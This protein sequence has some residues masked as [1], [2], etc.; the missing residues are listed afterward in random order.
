MLEEQ[1]QAT[2]TL[3]DNDGPIQVYCRSQNTSSGGP[4]VIELPSS[5]DDDDDDIGKPHHAQQMTVS[6]A[7]QHQGQGQKRLCLR[8]PPSNEQQAVRQQTTACTQIS[9]QP[10]L[11]QVRQTTANQPIIKEPTL[12]QLPIVEPAIS[13]PTF[14]Q[15]SVCQTD[16][17]V[18]DPVY[19][20]VSQSQQF[21]P[22]LNVQLD[23][24]PLNCGDNDVRTSDTVATGFL[25]DLNTGV[26][27]AVS[28]ATQGYPNIQPS[29][30]NY[31]N[32]PSP[33][34]S[35]NTSSP[36]YSRKLYPNGQCDDSAQNI[37]YDT[38]QG[39]LSDGGYESATS[40]YS[41][42]NTASP[43]QNVELL[44]DTESSHSIIQGDNTF[45]GMGYS[46]SP[47]VSVGNP[48]VSRANVPFSRD[49]LNTDN[50]GMDMLDELLKSFNQD[51]GSMDF[52]F[53]TVGNIA[54]SNT[55]P[56]M[57]TAEPM[58][59]FS[60]SPERPDSRSN[61]RPFLRSLLNMPENDIPKT[62][63]MV[64]EFS[65]HNSV[66]SPSAELSSN[67]FSP[68]SD[69]YDSDSQQSGYTPLNPNRN[70]T[71]GKNIA[72]KNIASENRDSMEGYQKMEISD[73][74]HDI[75]DIALNF[76]ENLADGQTLSD[77]GSDILMDT[78]DDSDFSKFVS[79]ILTQADTTQP[80][81]ATSNM[82]NKSGITKTHSK[83]FPK[84]VMSQSAQGKQT[85][86]RFSVPVAPR[87]KLGAQS[88]PKQPQYNSSNN[89]S[90]TSLHVDHGYHQTKGTKNQ[91]S[92]MR[93]PNGT[94]PSSR[95]NG[96]MNGNSL[97]VLYQGPKT[98][99]G[100]S[101]N[102]MSQLEKQLRG[103]GR[104]ATTPDHGSS[105]RSGQPKPFLEQLLT[106]ELTKD[107]YI[108]MEKERREI[109]RAHV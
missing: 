93:S 98:C 25:Q 81:Y 34:C 40:P 54:S 105:V 69:M 84:V 16:Q 39:N 96:Q 26:I 12:S 32:T 5:D 17:V 23:I 6:H 102:T 9:D 10:S 56:T 35:S 44:Q 52:P 31:S 63:I 76:L 33:S 50:L 64:K 70:L 89:A 100:Q 108:E 15:T 77:L 58:S 19:S 59:V 66:D 49:P 20:V 22:D 101:N 87:T 67:G 2:L 1:R 97:R 79:S 38:S 99:R 51:N 53:S 36:P 48:E 46:S 68:R 95:V 43:L 82:A 71:N 104:D 103:M 74:P 62:P 75:S 78:G 83:Q 90:F 27:P 7:P 91:F 55:G 4:K 28:M 92:K 14:S 106:G 80:Q 18:N 60:P 29:P 21:Q 57:S 61:D 73:V 45:L 42:T 41:T 3:P 88:A 24:K 8:I 30:A 107:K 11:S 65:F 109:G 94:G 13:Q 85:G 47:P 86:S 37:A 72:N